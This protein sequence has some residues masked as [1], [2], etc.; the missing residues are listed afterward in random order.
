M[1]SHHTTPRL[2]GYVVAAIFLISSLNVA[3]AVS[4]SSAAEATVFLVSPTQ[5]PTSAEKLLQSSSAGVL[6]LSIPGSFGAVVST[7]TSMMLT[8]YG[9]TALGNLAVFSASDSAGLAAVITQIVTSGGTLSTNGT[10]SGSG[11]QIVVRQAPLGGGSAVT[12]IVTYN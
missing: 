3:I 12:A 4:N 11:V 5:V 2:C 7:M 9:T 1:K 8:A 10:L 6:I